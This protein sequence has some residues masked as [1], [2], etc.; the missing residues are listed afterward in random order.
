MATLDKKSPINIT[1]I[2]SIITIACI[3][4]MI[5]FLINQK[6]RNTNSTDFIEPVEISKNIE[7]TDSEGNKKIVDLP[8]TI[9][10][11]K[12]FTVSF[13]IPI[14]PYITA[15]TLNMRQQYLNSTIFVGDREVSRF[16]ITKK[17]LVEREFT[18][19]MQLIDL[20]YDT[21]EK[22]LT[23]RYEPVLKNSLTYYIEPMYMG[24]HI[25]FLVHYLLRSDGIALLLTF[26]TFVLSAISLIWAK[27]SE[28]NN[29]ESNSFL[30]VGLITCCYTLYAI[31][32]Y[33][34]VLYL[35]NEYRQ[36]LYYAEFS[37]L[38]FATYLMVVMLQNALDPKY[39]KLI[40]IGKQLTFVNFVVQTILGITYTLPLEKMLVFTYIILFTHLGIIIYIL[41]KTDG[42]KYRGKEDIS[43]TIVPCMIICIF[44]L[45]VY[46][47]NR[48]IF[49]ISLSYTAIIVFLSGNG[50]YF[51][52]NY[53]STKARNLDTIE[54]KKM[55]R[56]DELTGVYNRYAFDIKLEEIEK[57]KESVYIT[58]V[59]IDNLKPVNDNLGH[60]YGDNVIIRVANY[61]AQ[62]MPHSSIYRI[63]GDEFIV[64]T[65][66][67]YEE[68]ARKI[69]RVVLFVD[70]VSDKYDV[71]FSLGKSF[72]DAKKDRTISEVIK[73]CDDIMYSN[74]KIYKDSLRDSNIG[75]RL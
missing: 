3:V 54:Y 53:L 67:D 73:M 46:Y 41:I 52:V 48:S 36:L 30:K 9:N 47:V 23:I 18:Y 61:L 64:I 29:I 11:N 6:V 4:S 25:N 32:R 65:E 1:N 12:P 2:L 55:M 74:K 51:V 72:Y 39:D 71:T 56:I 16:D 57:N 24:C 19:A 70:D 26:V 28:R 60:Y 62:S 7:I 10:T 22:R 21:H 8:Y 43:I 38:M 40:L 63:G 14:I 37:L 50:Y 58:I 42:H 5:F 17:S 44:V 15:K 31:T 27:I 75:G 35:F 13:D 33:D 66:K 20:P 34:V 49:A 69:E 59:D 68:E 45:V